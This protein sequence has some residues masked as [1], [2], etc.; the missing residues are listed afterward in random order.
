MDLERTG[1]GREEIPTLSAYSVYPTH[2]S[3]KRKRSG[4]KDLWS[5]PV[6]RRSAARFGD[7]SLFDPSRRFS[8][9]LALP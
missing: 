5:R 3:P 4:D 8:W 9:L 2:N 6:L 1:F 7:I